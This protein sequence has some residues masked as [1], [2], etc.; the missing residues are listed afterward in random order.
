MI[1]HSASLHAGYELLL[2][3]TQLPR[4]PQLPPKSPKSLNFYELFTNWPED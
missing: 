2:T 4:R 1:P 3:V